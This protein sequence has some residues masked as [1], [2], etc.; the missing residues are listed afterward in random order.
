MARLVFLAVVCLL[1]AGLVL[2]QEKCVFAKLNQGLSPESWDAVA[3]NSA[4][5]ADISDEDEC[6]EACCAREDCQ[7]A[8]IRTP[9]D[10]SPQCFLVNCM[11]D[12]NDVCV[13]E[14]SDHSKTY[15][16]TQ[17]SDRA[18]N[19][20]G[21]HRG[22]GNMAPVVNVALFR[23]FY[24]PGRESLYYSQSHINL[25]IFNVTTSLVNLR[26]S[27]CRLKFYFQDPLGLLNNNAV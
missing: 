25:I 26:F 24:G 19:S 17:V 7:L 27:N 6:R 4:H 3:D 23:W 13:L 5:L 9:A 11:K 8:L 21:K 14:A 22:G 16:K 18:N 20:T 10:G 12:G 2:G 1:G 15:L